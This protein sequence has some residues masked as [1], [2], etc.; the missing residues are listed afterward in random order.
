MRK[1][2]RTDAL[3]ALVRERDELRGHCQR[4]QGLLEN[5]G[6]PPG[7]FYS[8]VV[9]IADPHAVRATRGRLDAPA[10]AGIDIDPARMAETL[11]LLAPH[12]A[13]FPFPLHHE[14]PYRFC[15]ENPFF[16]AHD[17]SALF[18]MLLAFRPRRVIEVGC[19]HSSCLLL[20]TNEIF[21]DGAMELT[22]IDPSLDELRSLFGPKGAP[23]AR[24]MPRKL[25]DVPS[26]VFEELEENDILFIDS[27]HVLK[28]GS[29]VNDYLF[30]I[31]PLLRPGVLIHIH[32][33]LYPFEYPEEWVLE[34]KRSWN[35]AYAL[36]AF[37]QY[38]SS[39]EIL[40]WAN[41]VW[42]YLLDDLRA[43]MPLSLENGGGSIW[44][45]RAR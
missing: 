45:R 2:V 23:G 32:D 24:L 16:G 20:D 3:N 41:F 15:R 27:S 34:H 6:F 30:R 5:T 12:H 25:Q 28:T 19:G 21:F 4:L 7:H 29:D 35:E 18:S 33:I 11:R 10:L 42:T 37:L 39:F 40:Y 26:G 13:R 31:L 44:L 8:P 17:A 9:D 1:L 38:N 43:L 36:R 22:M 14:E